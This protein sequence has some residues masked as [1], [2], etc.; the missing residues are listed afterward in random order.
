MVDEI[1]DPHRLAVVIGQWHTPIA[2]LGFVGARLVLNAV[3]THGVDQGD[4]D[5]Q[6]GTAL[7]Q[8][9]QRLDGV[10]LGRRLGK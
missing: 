3:L 6:R 8:S 2:V 5:Q 7:N 1:V 9:I 10:L 4:S